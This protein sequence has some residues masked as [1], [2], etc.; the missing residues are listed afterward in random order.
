[1]SKLFKKAESTSAF[2][3]M[4]L[5]GFPGSG[6]TYTA[7][8]IAIGLVHYMREKNIAGAD[9][10]IFFLD[11]ETG[12]DWIEP[13][14]R[15][16]GLDIMVAKTRAFTDLCA[17]V[18]EA[19]AEASVLLIDSITHFWIEFTDT[20][21]RKK[22][23]ER[24][25][26]IGRLEFQDWGYLKGEWRRKFTD[27]FVN[28]PL[29]IIMCGR[30]GYEYDHYEDDTGKKQIEKTGVK[31]KAEGEL[32]FEPSILVMM[33]REQDLQENKLYH[34]AHVFKD[35][36]S[37]AKTLDGKS[38]RNP[39]FKTFLPHI[40]FL[41]L[42]GRQLGVDTSRTSE[43]EIPTDG[44]RDTTGVRREIEVELIQATFIEHIPGQSAAD[45][46]RKMALLQECF[47]TKSWTEIE[48]LMPL[49]HLREGH[50][51]LKAKLAP[52]PPAAVAA[53]AADNIPVLTDE[54][55]IARDEKIAKAKL[56]AAE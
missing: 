4:G 39:T 8:D 27:P 5:M 35:R 26:S 43:A 56:Q 6:K 24:K 16:A 17:A 3:K 12:S 7:T 36:R 50:A 34:V 23:A 49:E 19:E 42:G 53:Q 33:E 48:R 1:M 15:A 55:V 18:K 47:N 45:K 41:N 22:A 52:P 31:M 21:Q 37:D 20:Y 13:K 54:E 14:V 30:A 9:R 32:G 10:P 11:T 28:S 44:G 2:L 29:H 25:R 51:T 40:E 38:F 46:Q